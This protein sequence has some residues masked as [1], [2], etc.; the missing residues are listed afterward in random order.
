MLIEVTTQLKDKDGKVV[1]DVETGQTLTK[2]ILCQPT[3]KDSIKL[4]EKNKVKIEKL[5]KCEDFKV[6][7]G[8]YEGLWTALFVKPLSFLLLL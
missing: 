4:Y 6:N 7:S 5:P 8:K 3:N 1:K 2:N